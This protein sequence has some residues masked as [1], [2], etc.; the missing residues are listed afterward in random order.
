MKNNYFKGKYYKFQTADGYTFALIDGDMADSKVI[1]FIDEEKTYYIN[2]KEQIKIC[3]SFFSFDIS[4]DDLTLKGKIG[5][6]STHK[7][8]KDVMG[9]L[10]VIPVECRHNI[11]S[12]YGDTVGKILLNGRFHSLLGGSCYIEGDEGINFPREYIWMNV[13]NKDYGFTLAIASIPLGKKINFKGCFLVYKD[14]LNEYVYSTL[15]GLKIDLISTN[16]ISLHKG[17]TKF[18]ILLSNVEGK[19]LLAPKQG[20]MA[21]SIH[22]AIKSKVSFLIKNKHKIIINKDNVYAS[23]ERVNL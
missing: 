21:Y 22:E 5:L 4:Q 18:E 19:P 12:M 14:S 16:K 15:N 23:V 17:S 20:I 1:Q 8:K 3:N 13:L 7:P 9:V 11:Y 10:R 2:N 6:L